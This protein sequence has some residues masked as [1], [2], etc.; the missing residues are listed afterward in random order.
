MIWSDQTA[1]DFGFQRSWWQNVELIFSALK[2]CPNR[3]HGQLKIYYAG[4]NLVTTEIDF[5]DPES[6][7]ETVQFLVI[8]KEVMKSCTLILWW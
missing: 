4:Y 7:K 2:L 6:E 3:K 5:L 1:E 8:V